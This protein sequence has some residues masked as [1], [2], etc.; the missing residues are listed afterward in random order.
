[1]NRRN[2]RIVK[3]KNPPP[4]MKTQPRQSLG[5]SIIDGIATG[6]TFGTGSALGHRAMDA[7]F[8]PRKIE[9]DNTPNTSN[10]NCKILIESFNKCLTK[11]NW[12]FEKCD[13]IK[14]LLSKLN[15]NI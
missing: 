7:V 10:D 11:N 8:G 2:K 12:E 4:P 13:D 1:M 14:D 6:I 3:S 9:V 15:C 5:G